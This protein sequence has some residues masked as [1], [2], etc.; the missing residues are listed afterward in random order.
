LPSA[1]AKS[2]AASGILPCVSASTVVGGVGGVGGVGAALSDGGDA[3]ADADAAVDGA[4]TTDAEGDA[5]TT[6]RA[7]GDEAGATLVLAAAEG[8]S[9]VVASGGEPQARSAMAHAA[10]RGGEEERRE[11]GISSGRGDR[12]AARG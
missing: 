10:N 12:A 3:G 11:K 7:G 1:I 2:R 4:A 9:G 5:S 8:A 6:G